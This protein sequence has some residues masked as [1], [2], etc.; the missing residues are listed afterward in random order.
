MST[1]T[2]RREPARDWPYWTEPEHLTLEDRSVAYRRAGEGPTVLFLHGGGLTR[3]WL[4]F[5][6]TL[7]QS[8]DLVAPEHP[9]FGDSDLPAHYRT[10][11]DFALHY[12]EFIRALDLQNVHLVGTSLG[13]RIAG[14]LATMYPERFASLT[15]IVPAGLRGTGSRPDPFRQTAEQSLELLTNGRAD[16]IAEELAGF[17]Y[18]ENVIQG[19]REDTTL[20]L[21]TFTN[22]YD[23]ELEHRLSRVQAPTLIIDAE[24]DRVLGPGD[25]ARFAELI[26]GAERV[27]IEG[28]APDAPSSHVL[29]VEQPAT[30]AAAIVAHVQSSA[31]SNE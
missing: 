4:P 25:A 9:G 27:V 18:P 17:E 14:H 12:D 7:A 2:E 5:H 19:Y 23:R 29:H 15:L 24:D 3:R 30:V 20:A 16:A 8:V 26:P 1:Q 10:F 28:P 21:L 11:T 31:A 22:R 13:G 6:E